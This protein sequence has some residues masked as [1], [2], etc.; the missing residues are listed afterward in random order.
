MTP[1]VPLQ[2]LALLTLFLP[3]LQG[4]SIA[5]A[6]GSVGGGTGNIAF[7]FRGG[8]GTASRRLPAHL[9][10]YTLGVLVQT[11]FGGVESTHY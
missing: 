1:P 8:I 6:E 2:R 11:N 4:V 9:G 10:G 5:V 3:G 7:G